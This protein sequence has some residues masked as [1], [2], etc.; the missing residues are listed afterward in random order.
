M[1]LTHKEHT[2]R[3]GWCL[4]CHEAPEKFIRPRDQVFNMAYKAPGRKE[5]RALGS[6]LVEEYNIK[7]GQLLNCSICHR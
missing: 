3:M 5:Q 6:R 2:L 4:K 7:V 1:K